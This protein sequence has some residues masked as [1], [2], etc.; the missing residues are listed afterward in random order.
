MS[1][2][3]R[4][5]NDNSHRRTL[6]H[7]DKSICDK[8]AAKFLLSGLKIRKIPSEF[9]K[10]SRMFAHSTP[11]QLNIQMLHKSVR[12]EKLIS[13]IQIENEEVKLIFI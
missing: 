12:Q 13:G 11:P 4:N 2:H 5:P 8:I 9:I 6:P 7:P 3:Y 1:T 10:N